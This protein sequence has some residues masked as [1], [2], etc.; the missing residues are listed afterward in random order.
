MIECVCVC[1]QLHFNIC[2]DMGGK[3]RQQNS[4]DLIPKSAEMSHEVKAG[5]SWN[6]MANG[7]AR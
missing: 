5:S 6:V 1:A 4:Y 3:I 2:K 7:D